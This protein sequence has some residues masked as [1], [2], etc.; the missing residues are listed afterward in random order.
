MSNHSLSFKNLINCRLKYR[1]KIIFKISKS[2]NGFKKKTTSSSS[3]LEMSIL[4]IQLNDREEVEKKCTNTKY[5]QIVLFTFVRLEQLDAVGETQ[6]R[7]R[8]VRLDLPH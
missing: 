4:E 1:S 8:V 7:V 2:K 5:C 3:E 6:I